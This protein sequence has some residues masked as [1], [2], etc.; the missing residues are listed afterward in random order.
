MKSIRSPESTGKNTK[1]ASLVLLLATPALLAIPASVVAGCFQSFDPGTVSSSQ[2]SGSST[3]ASPGDVDAALIGA[4]CANN[5]AE[6]ADLCG[7]PECALPDAAIPPFLDIPVIVYQPD[8]SA[9][10]FGSAA[11]GTTTTDPCVAVEAESVV[12]RQRSCAPCHGP[13]PA[14]GFNGFNYVLDD[15]TLANHPDNENDGK[16]MVI[17]GD[18][19]DSY[20]YQRVVTGLAGAGSGGMPP[21]P[22]G[23]DLPPEAGAAVVYPTPA[24][25]SVLYGWILNCIVGADGGAYA[26]TYY[27]GSFGPAGDSGASAAGDAGGHTGDSGASEAGDAGGHTGDSGASAAEDAGAPRD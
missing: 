11:P 27:G 9:A 15:M 18:P 21:N 2:P 17:P 1:R 5:S 13:P 6:C 12:I 8:G 25:V 16:I 10:G 24:D 3:L 14:P 4:Q 26:T 20:V 22:V 19:A 23:G 7:S